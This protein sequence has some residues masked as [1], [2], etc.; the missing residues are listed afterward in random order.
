V[1]I[2]RS[3]GHNA[4]WLLSEIGQGNELILEITP[5]YYSTWD[6]SNQHITKYKDSE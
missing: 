5:S 2:V 1:K 6:Y 3:Q 4:K